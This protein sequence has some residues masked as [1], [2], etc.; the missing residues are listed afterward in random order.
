[1][2]ID[3]KN[4]RIKGWPKA[5][6]SRTRSTVSVSNSGGSVQ[7]IL[8]VTVTGCEYGQY[9][10]TP[11][12]ATM[13]GLLT[14]TKDNETF[15]E[16]VVNNTEYSAVLCLPKDTYNLTLTCYLSQQVLC[17]LKVKMD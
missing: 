1:M 4:N 6:L 17:F 12:Y 14:V 5:S 8:Y 9:L 15:F 11:S 13:G 16:Q 3:H 10:Y 7:K 2:S